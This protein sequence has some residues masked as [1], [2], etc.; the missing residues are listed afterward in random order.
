MVGGN[1]LVT[2]PPGCDPNADPRSAPRC[3]DEMFALFVDPR[4]DDDSGTGSR[5]AP[6]RTI[7][8]AA[9]VDRLRGRPRIYVCNEAVVAESVY[10]PQDVSLVGGFNCAWRYDGVATRIAPA[11]GIALKITSSPRRVYVSDVALTPS[12]AERDGESSISVLVANSTVTFRRVRA[13]AGA[14]RSGATPPTASNRSTILLTGRD[15]DGETGGTEKDCPCPLTGGS[16]G[17]SGAYNGSG[18]ACTDGV[19]GIDGTAGRVGAP[20]GRLGR[21]SN[22]GWL[23]AQGRD[24][25]AGSAGVGGGGGGANATNDSGGGGGGC[26]GCGGAGGLGGGGGGASIALAMLASDVLLDGG[27]YS[28]ATA[29]DGAAGGPGEEGERGGQGG[30]GASP[31]SCNGGTGGAGGNGGGGGGGAGGVSVAVLR[32]GGKLQLDATVQLRSGT[33]G[34]GG[35]TGPSTTVTVGEAQRGPEWTGG[36][37]ILSL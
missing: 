17:G 21:L 31:S 12:D 33:S 37:P 11:A 15:A 35:P 6:L 29:G 9:G 23:P 20:A 13:V 4:V 14:G 26:G 34:V 22:D 5:T 1:P 18:A 24:A 16:V 30:R 10:L 25:E 28:S 2:P 27:E 19:G 3:I 32:S 36:A 7:A 8:A